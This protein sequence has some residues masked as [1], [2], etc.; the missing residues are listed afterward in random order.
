MGF[1]VGTY[2]ERCP[3]CDTELSQVKF[4]EIQVRLRDEARKKAGEIEQGKLAARQELEAEFK[5]A[6]EK[7][8]LAAAKKATREADEQLTKLAS[9]RDEVASKLKEAQSRQAEVR[10]EAELE[11]Q[12]H[13][14]ALEKKA[15]EQI[16]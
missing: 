8:K 11:V 14:Q 10:K 12:T 13:K 16:D 1:E 4:R 7:E 15:K 3:L 5:K 6:L 9:E 2:L